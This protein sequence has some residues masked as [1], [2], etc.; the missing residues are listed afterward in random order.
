MPKKLMSLEKDGPKR[1]ELSWSGMWNDFTVNLDGGTVISAH[2]SSDIKA[3][4]SA[5]LPDGSTLDVRLQTG[6]GNAGLVIL[7]NGV[8][9]PGSSTDPETLVKTAG[10]IVYAIAVL[11]AIIVVI[12]YAFDVQFLK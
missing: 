5:T 10:G 8:P 6:F 12:A 2:G 9:L 7:R 11:N 1:L 4:K 3:G